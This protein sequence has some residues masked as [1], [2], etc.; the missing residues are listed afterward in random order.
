LKCM[1]DFSC[2]CWLSYERPLSWGR[3][4]AQL[5]DSFIFA[6]TMFPTLIAQYAG[7]TAHTAL[8]LLTWLISLWGSC[9]LSSQSWT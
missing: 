6:L 5:I 9:K 7:P 3:V 1:H 4:G 8:A 2:T